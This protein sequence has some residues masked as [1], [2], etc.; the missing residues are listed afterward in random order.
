MKYPSETVSHD[1]Y[2]VLQSS[3]QVVRNSL[4]VSVEVIGLH[5]VTASVSKHE[6][7]MHLWSG[8]LCAVKPHLVRQLPQKLA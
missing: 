6:C 2:V 4:H 3:R 8:L 1:S 5:V 7:D